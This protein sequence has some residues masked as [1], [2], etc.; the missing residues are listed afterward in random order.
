MTVFLNTQEIAELDRQNPSTRSNGGF[1]GL[2]VSLAQ[3]VDRATGRLNLTPKDLERI[4]R[5]AF[6]Y[7]R[8]GWQGRLERI[9][10]RN[11]GPS[12]G[13]QIARPAA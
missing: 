4:T 6:K 1:Q 11:L 9:F 7:K 8:G 13:R 10:G 12:L 5:Y 2:I 3:R